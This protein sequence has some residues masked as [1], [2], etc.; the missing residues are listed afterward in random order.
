MAEDPEQP[1][2]SRQ[3]NLLARLRLQRVVFGVLAAVLVTGAALG[4]AAYRRMQG[5]VRD[6]DASAESARADVAESSRRIDTL[7]RQAQRDRAEAETL[8]RALGLS[9]ARQAVSEARDGFRERAAELVRDS[10]R[11]GAPA[12][13][14]IAAKAARE[15]TV[16]F[17]GSLHPEAPV[18]C[19]AATPDGG[20]LVVAR[21]VPGACVVELY[22]GTDGA[23][24]ASGS[25][26]LA[27]DKQPPL[28]EAVLVDPAGQVIWLA[29]Q[30]RVFRAEQAGNGL[31]FTEVP[32]GGAR[33]LHLSASA[34]WHS[35]L[36]SRG[37]EGLS[38]LSRNQQ[39]WEVRPVPMSGRDVRA[40]CFA[41]PGEIYVGDGAGLFRLREG[42]QAQPLPL[43]LPLPLLEF[44]F[45]AES[46]R[47]TPV[48]GGVAVTARSA[49]E[50]EYLVLESPGDRVRQRTRKQLPARADGALQLLADGTAMTGVGGG[51]VL[52]FR[53]AGES[54]ITLG[55]YG[56]SFAAWHESGL[57]FGNNQ[58]E[59]GLRLDAR[60]G[61]GRPIA[62]LAPQVTARAQPFGFVTGSPEGDRSVWLLASGHSPLPGASR[63]FLAGPQ[64]TLTSGEHSS[65]LGTGTTQP[66]VLLG[67]GVG[68]MLLWR[69]GAKLVAVRADGSTQPM[70]CA[71]STPPDDVAVAANFG[72][73]VL[74]WQDALFL[75]DL[76]GDPR[77]LV[78]TP[79]T[80]PDLMALAADGLTLA[81][82]AGSAVTVRDLAGGTE[83]TLIVGQSPRAIA[84]LYGGSVLA[85]AE[86]DELVLYEVD[87]GRELARFAGAV[88][89]LA[90]TPGNDLLLVTGGTLRAVEFNAG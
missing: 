10:Q 82:A 30:G 19:G 55:G 1:E 68:G 70:D 81:L 16:R 76:R 49:G 62:L 45:E 12:W 74:R 72:A 46:L 26:A 61:P 64:V 54:E 6:A 66:G 24:L 29:A 89:S 41:G 71:A 8:S 14:P 53:P 69:T 59:I 77:P 79:G 33:V 4:L 38:V 80:S 43:P 31:A 52:V 18:A 21:N 37:R 48:A 58:G 15:S 13:W 25:P 47:M 65:F 50:I 87:G 3:M 32:G 2:P 90:A 60:G 39:R 34:D 67:A 7:N 63:V 35:L 5:M 40:A 42:E 17:R 28:A 36:V 88:E 73:A 78:R 11:Y 9:C 44:A 27:A 75:T 23:M 57:L 84:L 51:R 22:D 20:R 83:R 85:V 56:P 86:A